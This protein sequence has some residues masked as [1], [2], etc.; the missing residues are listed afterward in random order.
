VYLDLEIENIV[1]QNL[2]NKLVQ[3]ILLGYEVA[4]SVA[5]VL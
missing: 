4:T 1:K 5:V 3:N 2:S